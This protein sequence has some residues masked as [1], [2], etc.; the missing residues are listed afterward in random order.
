MD[1]DCA[2]LII[3]GV[4]MPPP[5]GHDCDYVRKRSALV[6]QAVQMVNERVKIVPGC[7]VA[8]QSAL[9]TKCF[10]PCMDALAEPVVER[11]S[12]ARGPKTAR[13]SS[14]AFTGQNGRFS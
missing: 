5:P 6:E 13:K 3:R 9:W 4:R 14:D 12:A 2:E 8:E 11:C 1:C 7:D 10:A